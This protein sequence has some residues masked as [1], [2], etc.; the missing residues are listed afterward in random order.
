DLTIRVNEQFLVDALTVDL[1]KWENRGWL[2]VQ[3]PGLFRS[4][5][6][7]LRE[8]RAPTWVQFAS[9]TEKDMCIARNLAK[10]GAAKRLLD[11]LPIAESHPFAPSGAKLQDLTIKRSYR[12]IL[13]RRTPVRRKKTK[14]QLELCRD[15][16][17]ANQSASPSNETIWRSLSDDDFS[18]K[19]DTFFW[20]TIH[21][22]FKTG[23]FWKHI[24][25]F[26][27]RGV[28]PEC[29]T[30]EDL[31]HVLLKCK[32]PGQKVIWQ[33]AKALVEKRGIAWPDLS[34][35]LIMSVGLLEPQGN[36]GTFKLGDRRLLKIVIAESAYLIWVIR[37]ERRIEHEDDRNKWKS[38]EHII[39]LWIQ[40]VNQRLSIDRLSTN[41]FK[42]GK[43]ALKK[44]AVLETWSGV[45][46]NED[47]LPDDWI[48]EPR[49]L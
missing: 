2:D 49:V 37:C 20:K 42:F 23:D 9:S 6:S 38:D 35:G 39:N 5:V 8:R 24:P 45:L 15:A 33:L 10:S 44:E 32:I 41:R 22:A 13:R 7:H 28:C 47:S 18:N 48:M 12:E 16:I 40:T 29:G 25:N 26:E 46:L 43:M 11:Q 14:A 36:E 19:Q 21:D 17:K 4:V 30:K 27:G 34:L 31:E 3:C 1:K